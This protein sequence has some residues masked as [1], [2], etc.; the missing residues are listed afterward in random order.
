V[1]LALAAA[2]PACT[3]TDSGGPSCAGGKCDTPDDDPDATPE[4]LC[5]DRRADALEGAQRAFTPEFIRWACSDVEGV[6]AGPAGDDRG[7]EY[8]E[9]YAIVQPPPANQGGALPKAVQIGR[10]EIAPLPLELTDDQITALDDAS[11]AIVGQCVFTAWHSD[12]PG[13]LPVC[14]SPTSCPEI[15]LPASTKPPAWLTRLET[16]FQ[17]THRVVR[18]L[19]VVNS[20]DAAKTLLDACAARA[21]QADA[22]QADAYLRGCMV[23]GDLAA[24][25][26]CVYWRRS[27]P[28]ICTAAMRLA[29]C[30]CGI[31]LDGDDAPDEISL[32][33][34]L[35]PP[36][37][38]KTGA[39]TLR[40]FPLGTWSGADEL[41]AGCRF[42][43][44][45]EDSRTLV[46][47][48]LTAGDVL[49]GASDLKATCQQKYGANV[50]VHIPVPADQIVCT[51]PGEGFGTERNC[52]DT[53]WVVE[54]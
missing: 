14:S 21:P 51:P 49:D 22:D 53:P 9:Y 28:T 15:V 50:V 11:D 13:P 45:G 20:N 44:I 3:T 31:D 25:D 19:D 10:K 30:G 40:G 16:G 26:E 1:A 7:Q 5:P 36:Q 35:V 4:A 43:D 41:P 27:D 47:C 24:T 32:G 6:T 8:C 2:A 33:T 37:P 42:V 39:V 52:G 48:D 18:M 29:E 46:T 12:V 17:I 38:D 34:A 54:K 23:C